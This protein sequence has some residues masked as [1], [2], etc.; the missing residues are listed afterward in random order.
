M[1]EGENSLGQ[2]QA[3]AQAVDVIGNNKWGHEQQRY[4]YPSEFPKDNEGLAPRD[5]ILEKML[6]S[7]EE[8]PSKGI[9]F[10]KYGDI[11]VDLHCAEEKA[12]FQPIK[13][14]EDAKLH[15]AMHENIR[16]SGYQEPTPIQAYSIPCLLQGHDLLAGAQTGKYFQH[17]KVHSDKREVA[18]KQPLF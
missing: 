6:F 10:D 4:E 17:C 7:V 14:F 12:P 15:P 1:T 13:K 11:S 5:E 9:N 18:V 16:L 2:W 8:R 3:I